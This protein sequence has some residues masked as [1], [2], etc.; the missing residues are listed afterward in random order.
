MHVGDLDGSRSRAAPG[1][2]NANATISVHDA[3]HHPVPG[4]VVIGEWSNGPTLSCAT[5][6]S[7]R[8]VITA[9]NLPNKTGSALLTIVT[10]THDE[11]VYL[12]GAIHDPDGGSNGTTISIPR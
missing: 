1:S 5:D 9:T 2:W 8:C 11:F 4:T 3:D 7:G 6:A 10:V 12:Q